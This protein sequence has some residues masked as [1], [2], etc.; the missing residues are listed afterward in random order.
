MRVHHWQ[1]TIPALPAWHHL[2]DGKGRPRTIA[3]FCILDNPVLHSGYSDFDSFKVKIGDMENMR[4]IEDQTWLRHGKRE[5]SIKEQK[6]KRLKS[7][8]DA[9]KIRLSDL[10]NWNIQFFLDRS[11]PSRDRNLVCFEKIFSYPCKRGTSCCL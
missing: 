1:G 11:N 7:K 6:Q 3:T 9:A 10:Q 5:K 8:V 4:K 2:C